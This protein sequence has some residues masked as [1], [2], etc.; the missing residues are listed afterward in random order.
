MGNPNLVRNGAVIVALALI[1]IR[2]MMTLL[3]NYQSNWM[4]QQEGKIRAKTQ[5][6]MYLGY[7]VE[8]VGGTLNKN[9]YS[10]TFDEVPP[11]SSLG[12]D[13]KDGVRKFGKR[14]KK[15]F[16]LCHDCHGK[17]LR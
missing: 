5:S 8:I 11:R 2:S 3:P 6:K 17:E 13:L 4:S 10:E 1:M 16:I 9:N 15:W 12:G 7:G 14:N